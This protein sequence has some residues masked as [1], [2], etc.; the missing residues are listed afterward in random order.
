MATWLPQSESLLPMVWHA[1]LFSWNAHHKD[2]SYRLL[3]FQIASSCAKEANSSNFFFCKSTLP[4]YEVVEIL[5]DGH[6]TKDSHPLYNGH[7]LLESFNLH[8]QVASSGGWGGWGWLVPLHG[9][10]FS[11]GSLSV[12]TLKRGHS[13]S[14]HKLTERWSCPL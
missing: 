5:N 7:R 1:A 12:W 8:L 9:S 11:V 14:S 13:S 4:A 6:C 3:H 10:I 2:G